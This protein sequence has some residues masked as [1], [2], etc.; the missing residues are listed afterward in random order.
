M[1][2]WKPWIGSLAKLAASR[3][4]GCERRLQAF[5]EATIALRLRLSCKFRSRFLPPKKNSDANFSNGGTE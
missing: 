3:C 4:E 1:S 5:R 2:S